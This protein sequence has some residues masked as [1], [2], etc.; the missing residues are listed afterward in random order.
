VSASQIMVKQKGLNQQ[1]QINCGTGWPWN[2]KIVVYWDGS[3]GYFNVII[4][5]MQEDFYF[6]SNKCGADFCS[7]SMT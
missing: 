7:L 5:S 6:C 3:C 1:K 2:G 4:K